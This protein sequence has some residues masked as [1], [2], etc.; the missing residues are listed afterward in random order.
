MDERNKIR[1]E[2]LGKQ[3]VQSDA[4]SVMYCH[5]FTPKYII[6]W[7][8]VGKEGWGGYGFNNVTEHLLIGIRGK[9][10]PFGLSE[11]TIIKSKYVPRTHSVK[12]ED[13]W[14]LIEKCV[15]ATRWTHRKLE[16]NC[17]TPRKGWHPH[18][19]SITS[20]DIEE[21]QKLK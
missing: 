6:T 4:L 10:P 21:W 19:D 2:I 20:K 13:M 12:P 7:E 3:V 9:V 8:K 14:Q 5:G 16:L 1:A 18:G 17:R 11:K 15:A